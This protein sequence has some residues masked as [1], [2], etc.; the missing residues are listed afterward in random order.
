M[1]SDSRNLNKAET[2][3]RRAWLVALV[4]V[5]GCALGAL[6]DMQH[7]QRGYLLG[8]TCWCLLSVGCLGLMLMDHLF[9]ADWAVLARPILEAGVWTLPLMAALFVP[10]VFGLTDV[11]P[12]TSEHFR[13]QHAEHS[14]KAQYLQSGF[15][16]GRAAVYFALWIG[17]AFAVR[18]W[19]QT[20]PAGELGG[21]SPLGLRRLG[22]GGLVLVVFT[23]S[24][25][26]I[27]WVMS[28]EGPFST[29]WHGSRLE[30]R[31]LDGSFCIPVWCGSSAATMALQARP[32]R[33]G[34][35]TL[36]TCCWPS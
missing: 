9:S 4:A 32:K 34:L 7:F 24:L 29:R 10:L 12:W 13:E 6:V 26:G 11:Y 3:R 22:A 30:W 1:T 35:P 21:P 31:V 33:G 17:L 36:A 2:W 19:S 14:A 20:I 18:G 16:L 23:V 28:L 25:A 8:F 15:F 5:A 27:D